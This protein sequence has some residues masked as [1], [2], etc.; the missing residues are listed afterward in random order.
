MLPQTLYACSCMHD[1]HNNIKLYYYFHY[2]DVNSFQLGMH[3]CRIFYFAVTVLLEYLDF[4][5]K[6]EKMQL[7]NFKQSK[8]CTFF[9]WDMISSLL[10]HKFYQQSTYYD[11]YD[12]DYDWRESVILVCLSPGGK[13][14]TNIPLIDTK[15][16]L[17]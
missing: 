8:S 17:I 15:I 5:C 3:D 9:Y 13:N 12:N 2:N 7:L 6:R 10:Y 11:D 4:S 14:T 16:A 1:G